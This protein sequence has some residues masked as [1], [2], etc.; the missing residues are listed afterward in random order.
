MQSA[1]QA[2]WQRSLPETLKRVAL[3]QRVADG[4]K[5]CPTIEAALHTEAL[6]VAHKLAGSLGMFGFGEATLHARAIETHLSATDAPK[7]DEFARDV[8]ALIASMP[9]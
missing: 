1:M 5:D 3:L 8:D 7:P 6:S 9:D 2:I 4:L